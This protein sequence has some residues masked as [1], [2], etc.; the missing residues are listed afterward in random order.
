MSQ[1]GDI[2]GV[3]WC[4]FSGGGDSGGGVVCVEGEGAA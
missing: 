3:S 1:R 4:V 2:H